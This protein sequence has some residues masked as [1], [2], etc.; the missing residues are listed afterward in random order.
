MSHDINALFQKN[1]QRMVHEKL[2]VWVLNGIDDLDVHLIPVVQ[3]PNMRLALP[4]SQSCPG[5]GLKRFWGNAGNVSRVQTT[6][7]E[8]N[9]EETH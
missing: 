1:M 7:I 6:K 3:M 4:S 8:K 2:G 5:S 9:I